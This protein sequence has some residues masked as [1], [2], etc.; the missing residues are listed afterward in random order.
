MLR[1]LSPVAPPCI[2][3]NSDRALN[4]FALE[5]RNLYIVLYQIIYRFLRELLL[6][7]LHEMFEM[8]PYGILSLL[9]DIL[10]DTSLIVWFGFAFLH[11]D[12]TLRAVPD[13][14]SEPVTEEIAHETSLVVY[15]L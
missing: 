10:H 13:A 2:A 9:Y 11:R 15:D 12:G 7:M 8:R 14:G 3:P 6:A 4:A 1:G 5:L